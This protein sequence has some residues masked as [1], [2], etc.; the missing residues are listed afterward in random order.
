[1]ALMPEFG[2]MSLINFQDV[3]FNQALSAV[4]GVEPSLSLHWVLC[5]SGGHGI[6]I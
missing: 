1:M 4:P 5:L 6:R 2:V 3:H